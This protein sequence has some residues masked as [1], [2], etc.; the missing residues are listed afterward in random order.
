MGRSKA[1]LHRLTMY[2]G[3]QVGG[4]TER[5]AGADLMRAAEIALNMG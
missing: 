1:T 3:H 2:A 4:I 5:Y